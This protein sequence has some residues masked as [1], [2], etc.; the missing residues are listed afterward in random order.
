MAI[1]DFLFPKK[2][3]G[4]GRAG[5][6]VCRECI[7]KVEIPFLIC[8]QC[9]RRSVD[10]MTHSKCLRPQSLDGAI[11]LWKYQRVVRKA[12]LGLKYKFALEIAKELSAHATNSLKNYTGFVPENGVLIPIPLYWFRGNWR[13]FNQVEVIGKGLAFSLG[14]RFVPDLLVRKKSSRPQAE[15][16]GEQRRQNIKGVFALNPNYELL[17]TNYDSLVLFDDVWTT[18][19]T[20][21]EAAKVLKR[22]GVKKVWGMTLVRT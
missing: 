18:G 4:C 5:S 21:K 13:G 8:P 7:E 10:G 1:S 14:W 17:I 20:I 12:L 11:S 6:Y 9:G 3:L 22:A 15:L 19:A 16:R 2:C